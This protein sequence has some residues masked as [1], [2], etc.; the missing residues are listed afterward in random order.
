MQVFIILNPFFSPPQFSLWRILHDLKGSSVG[1]ELRSV[2]SLA[3]WVKFGRRTPLRE[4]RCHTGE[5]HLWGLSP[6]NTAPRRAAKDCCSIPWPG[7][8]V[9]YAL[10]MCLRDGALSRSGLRFGPAAEEEEQPDHRRFNYRP[11]LGDINGNCATHRG[12]TWRSCR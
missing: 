2:V 4:W 5:E 10:I 1:E 3:G 12:H 7:S 9:A 11:K 8:H 6:N